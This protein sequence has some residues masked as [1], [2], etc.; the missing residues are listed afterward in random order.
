MNK[1]DIQLLY[2]YDRWANLRVLQAAST[3]TPEQFTRDLGG[4]FRSVRD[5]LLHIIGGEWIWLT[6]WKDPPRDPASLADLKTL[7]DAQFRPED[8]PNVAAV[9]AKWTEVARAQAEFVGALTDSA[10]ET[11]LPARGSEL[12]LAHLMQHLANHSTYHRGQVALMLR[13]LGAEP[14]PTDFHV[15]MVES[16][17]GGS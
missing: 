17:A 10:L 16:A 8:F 1:G 2:E 6:Y 13:Q 12:K 4:G 11:M 3:L 14:L 15:F 7:R 5:T 9:K